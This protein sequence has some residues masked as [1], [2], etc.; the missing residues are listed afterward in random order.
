M[1]LICKAASKE[2][3]TFFMDLSKVYHKQMAR[4]S[5]NLIEY[6]LLVTQSTKRYYIIALCVVMRC[7][8]HIMRI[9][10]KMRESLAAKAPYVQTQ[11]E[12]ILILSAPS[13]KDN[14]TK[15]KSSMYKI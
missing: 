9:N 2:L 10:T 4:I 11:I 15:K 12:V 7:R 13:D 8:A 5:K 3:N 14:M 6:H 1:N